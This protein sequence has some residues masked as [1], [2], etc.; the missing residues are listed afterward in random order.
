GDVDTPDTTKSLPPV[1]VSVTDS[2]LLVVPIS[3]SPKSSDDGETVA[4]G[5]PGLGVP[6]F[7][8]AHPP[9]KRAAARRAIAAPTPWNRL[10]VLH[11]PGFE[12]ES[13]LLAR[14]IFRA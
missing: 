12:R 7:V 4:W 11:Q 13:S 1:L 14:V 6:P 5:L 8:I 2:E 9:A 10:P 3:W